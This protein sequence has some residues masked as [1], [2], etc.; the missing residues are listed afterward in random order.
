MVTT[1]NWLF[2]QR[3]QHSSSCDVLV[4][5]ELNDLCLVAPTEA[6]ATD[7][8]SPLSSVLCC[9]LIFSMHW[10][11]LAISVFDWT[12]NTVYH[13]LS[14]PPFVL[15]VC[16]LMSPPF[17]LRVYFLGVLCFWSV[18]LLWFTFLFYSW[19]CCHSFWQQHC[20]YSDVDQPARVHNSGAGVAG[21]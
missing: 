16:S 9:T 1:Q 10:T 11:T 4:K 18:C 17:L 6:Y 7:L 12:L 8:W 15:E 5:L 13:I 21:K 14:F 2:K 19:S 3:K 20:L